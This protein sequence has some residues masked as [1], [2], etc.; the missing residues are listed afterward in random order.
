MKDFDICPNPSLVHLSKFYLN[1][2]PIFPNLPKISP[3]KFVQIGLDFA[4]ICLKIVDR[5]CGRIPC[6]PSP[7]NTVWSYFNNHTDC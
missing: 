3:S 2:T 7:Y 5:G 1:F 4:Q 6:I